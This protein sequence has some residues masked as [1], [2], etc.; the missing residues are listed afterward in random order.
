LPE[1]DN[2]AMDAGGS[3]DL[4][5]WIRVMDELELLPN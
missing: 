3:A 5:G 2:I 4:N 1:K